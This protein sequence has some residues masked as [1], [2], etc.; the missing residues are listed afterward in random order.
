M[1]DWFDTTGAEIGIDP[2]LMGGSPPYLAQ[3]A[4]GGQQPQQAPQQ[5][6][7][8]PNNQGFLDWAFKNY[9]PNKQGF[10]DTGGVPFQDVLKRYSQ[11]TG[12]QAT[13]QGGP[14][15]DR[16]DFG[17]GTVD[18]R[19]SN[20]LLQSNVP[21]GGGG[22]SAPT[23]GGS[24][25]F[26]WQSGGSTPGYG[27]GGGPSLGTMG[28]PTAPTATDLKAPDPFT[29]QPN[30]QGAFTAPGAVP[31][32]NPMQAPQSQ[33]AQQ[34]G[35]Q[36]L[37]A[38]ERLSYNPMQT[39][40]AFSG[41]RQQTP[42]ALNYQNL[43]TPDN[44]QYQEYKG[45]TAAEL[46]QDPSYQFRNKASLDALE[47]SA[48]TKGVLR[49]GNTALGLIG[50]AGENASQ[51][52]QNVYNRGLATNQANNQ[53]RLGAAQF[54]AQTGLAYNQ[55]ANQNALQFG[56]QNIQN[57]FNAN[58]ANYGRSATEAQQG[59]SNQF[60]VNQANNQGQNAA[61]QAN[62]TNALNVGQANISNAL[63]AT[64]A[65][66]AA[67]LA[68][69]G[70]N[71]QQGFATNQANNQGA[72]AA[73]NQQFGQAATGYGLNQSAQNQQYQQA[74]GA[75]GLNAQTGLQYGSQNQQNQLANYQAQ[76]NAA[77]GL[78]NLNLGYQNSA[79]SYNLGLG[80]LGLGYG[81]LDLARTGQD[82]NQGL[83]TYDRNYQA[84]VTDPWNQQFQLAN[85]G[86]PGAPNSQQYANSQTDLITGAGN[87]QAAS[88]IA[89][90][91]AGA[92]AANSL[93]QMG[94]D[95]YLQYRYPYV[96]P[97]RTTQPVTQPV[98]MPQPVPLD[99]SQLPGYSTGPF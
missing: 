42:A 9:T 15:G 13:Y 27:G 3:P 62:N 81:N 74:L 18:A 96:T 8:A 54:D 90:G 99:R 86:N 40:Q 19:T 71:F 82:F 88:Q 33:Q 84:N 91:N 93:G 20:G 67:N 59:F 58:E 92:G 23:E 21:G 10:V 68:Y 94:Q 76:T 65:N 61:T 55:N 12:N 22:G 24:G 60:N 5:G 49:T 46:Q 32:Y 28:M 2:A 4:G 72:L 34:V 87:A 69:G 11:E 51:E 45:P 63:N 47:N 98:T 52:Y 89:G 43:S 77:L 48:A 97:P 79:N 66:N 95:A 14:S 26:P 16:V 35:Q 1:A 6:Q 30:Q 29:Y 44:F 83:A 50:K 53:G 78:G 36:T 17:Q 85:L 75:Y 80:N 57:A 7:W 64:Q 31:A 37:S 56:Q 39:P 41:D 73:Q 70:Q 38:P 25:P